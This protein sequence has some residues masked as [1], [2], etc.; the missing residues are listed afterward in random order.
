MTPTPEPPPLL[1]LTTWVMSQGHIPTHPPPSDRVHIPTRDPSPRGSAVHSG[2]TADYLL[3]AVW[4]ARLYP[5]E[6]S[7]VGRVCLRLHAAVTPRNDAG[8]GPGGTQRLRL[9]SPG[10][11]RPKA[12]MVGTSGQG[13]AMA[14]PSLSSP[15]SSSFSSSQAA[16]ALCSSPLLCFVPHGIPLQRMSG[17]WR[18]SRCCR[19]KTARASEQTRRSTLTCKQ[20][21]P[22]DAM[23]FLQ[24]APLLLLLAIS[25]FL[26]NPAVAPAEEGKNTKDAEHALLFEAMDVIDKHFIDLS[27]KD[28]VAQSSDKHEY[29]SVAW[30]GLKRELEEKRLSDRKETYKEIKKMLK[31]LGD[32]YTRFVSPADFVK[33]TKYDATGVGLAVNQDEEGLIIG[34]PPLAGSTAADA[35]DKRRGEEQKRREIGAGE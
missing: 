34:Y 29:N 10:Q 28:G 12:S 8:P 19:A 17:P 26:T 18:A 4:F 14:H 32:R 24:R 31:K 1:N 7:L 27:N 35:G 11:V 3:H 6:L 9:R 23:R 33:L 22:V 30:E 2:V 15:P 16:A 25:M 5:T 20:Q 21:G 13:A